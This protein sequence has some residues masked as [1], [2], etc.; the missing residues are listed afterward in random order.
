MDRVRLYF[1]REPSVLAIYVV[2][3]LVLTLWV[4]SNRNLTTLS[5]TVTISQKVPLVL[6][7]IGAAIVIIGRGI[8]LSVGAVLT[9]ANVTIAAGTARS[10]SSVPW[11]FVGLGI[12]LVAGL[13]NGICVAYLK[14][15]ALIV[16]LATQS[17]L[18]GTALYILPNPGGAVDRWMKDLPLLIIAGV[19]LMLLLLILVPL[20]TWYPLQATRYGTALRS[21]GGDA[22]AAFSTG[23]NTQ[24]VEMST[25]V[26][27]AFFAGLGGVVMSMNAGSGD[28]TIG[29]P[30]TLN[31]IAA[32]VL[33]G[34]ALS[35]GRGTIA[36]PIAGALVISFLGSLLF[37][38]DINPYW[39]YV[40]TGS[41]LVLAIAAPLIIRGISRR[42]EFA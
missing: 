12:A 25:Y 6:A 21:A 4:L 16:T 20:L 14:L 2:L 15:P 24:R 8:D 34:V 7:T 19:P 28:P 9:I 32:C 5:V 31:T 37:A 30:Y 27:S 26:L 41:L 3:A 38:L 11:I 33:G 42:K 40:V 29:V 1:K 39:Q 13:V 17:I 35:G 22:A 23:I 36:G 18:L 10:G